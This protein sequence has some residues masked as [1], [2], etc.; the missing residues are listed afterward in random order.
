MPL[1]QLM[2]TRYARVQQRRPS[3]FFGVDRFRIEF[4]MVRNAVDVTDR[5]SR[6]NTLS[7]GRPGVVLQFAPCVIEGAIPQGSQEARQRRILLFQ[8][9]PVAVAVLSRKDVMDVGKFDLRR[10]FGALS[11]LAVRGSSANASAQLPRDRRPG[12][13]SGSIWLLCEGV[14]D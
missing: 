7:S 11:R 13:A 3:F 10:E 8:I 9:R 5:A 2:E 12:I 14:Q 1:T 6:V 4:K